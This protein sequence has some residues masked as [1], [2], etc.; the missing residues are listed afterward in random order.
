M[1]DQKVTDLLVKAFG[2]IIGHNPEDIDT[3]RPSN[4]T[5]EPGQP[6]AHVIRPRNEDELQKIIQFANENSIN[7]TFVSSTGSHCKGGLIGLNEHM[8]VDLSLWKKIDWINRRNRVCQIQPGVTYG[9]I[10]E[11]LEPHGMTCSMPLA[12]R[13]GKSVIA[14]VM[15]REPS[16]WPNKQWD[17]S[18]PVASTEFIFGNGE[19]FR[20]GAAGGPGTLEE[21]RAIGGAQKSPLGPSQTD[22]HRVVQGAQ[23]TMGAVTWI[24]L[25]TELKPSVQKPCLLGADTLEEL[26]PFVYEVQRPWLG[27]HSFILDRTATAMMMSACNDKPFDAIRESLP[28]YLCLQNIAG[29]ERL[30]EEHVEYQEAD[31]KEIVSRHHLKITPSLGLV[32]AEDLLKTATRPCGESDWRQKLRG[33]CLSIFFMTTL[34]RT[35]D[36]VEV[37]TNVCRENSLDGETI[38]IYVQPVVQ[39]HSCHVEFMVPFD[40]K[41]PVQVELMRTL[42]QNAMIKLIE[43]GAFFSRPYGTSQ[44]IVFK[45]NPLNFQILKNV[46]EIFD[47]NRILNRGKWN[48]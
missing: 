42:E 3:F 28:R 34:D 9:E 25:R 15:D 33:H 36:F 1:E 38:G 43:A 32:S 7:L 16:T 4:P 48:L 21:Q 13:D 6:P 37:F 26:V 17:I 24:T 20:T 19:L 47:P 23:G 46:K 44:E 12:P 41:D 5:I 27:E 35:P 45:Q 31:I 40:H 22:F 8:M 11:A 10:L 18:D 2:D 14:A 30:P 39:N 29:F